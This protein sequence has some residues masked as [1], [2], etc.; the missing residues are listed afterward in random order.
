MLRNPPLRHILRLFT[1]GLL[2][3]PAQ[4]PSV[5]KR[6]ASR[7]QRRAKGEENPISITWSDVLDRRRPQQVR[8]CRGDNQNE[9]QHNNREAQGTRIVVWLF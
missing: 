7:G 4:C 5:E 1:R 3:R 6:P 2:H 8:T 9:C